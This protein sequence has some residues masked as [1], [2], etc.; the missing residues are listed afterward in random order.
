M[1]CLTT[2]SASG[3]G[4]TQSLRTYFSWEKLDTSFPASLA[5]RNSRARFRRTQ[6]LASSVDYRGERQGMDHVGERAIRLHPL[7][8]V[9]MVVLLAQ[10]ER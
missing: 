10:A 1:P 9:P 2:G 5:A 4:P 6:L 8:Q 3:E 7:S